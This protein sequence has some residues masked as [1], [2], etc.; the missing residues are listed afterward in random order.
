MVAFRAAQA[1]IVSQPEL[2]GTVRYV[3]TATF[4][5]DKL[6]ALP[7]RLDAEERRVREK[8]KANLREELKGQPSDS[9]RMEELVNAALE[10][11]RKEDEGYLTVQKEH[12]RVVSHWE[13]HYWGSARVY[14]LVGNGLAEAMKE[15]LQKN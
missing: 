5:Y 8:V 4:W 13:C 7:R 9:K 11:A 2:N 3:P 1:K 10:R 15:L 6:D 12:D 14:C